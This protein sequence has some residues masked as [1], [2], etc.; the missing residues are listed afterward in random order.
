[1]G[2]LKKHRRKGAD[3]PTLKHNRVFRMSRVAVYQFLEGPL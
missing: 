2:T 3:R 1:M